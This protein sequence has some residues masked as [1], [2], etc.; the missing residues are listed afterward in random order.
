M[1]GGLNVYAFFDKLGEKEKEVA[2]FIHVGV[3][4]L[5][6]DPKTDLIDKNGTNYVYWSDGSIRNLTESS[7]NSSTSMVIK[8]DYKYETTVKDSVK[9]FAKNSLYVPVGVG[10]KFQMGFRASLRVGVAY[11]LVM[12]DYV[13]GYKK[14]GNDSWVSASV[15]LN[16][17][18]GKKPSDPYSNVDFKSVDNS[19]TDGDGVKDLDDRCFGTPKGVKVD[20]KG[21]PEDKDDDGVFDYMDKELTTKKGAKVDGTGVTINEDAMAKRQLMWD[22]LSTERSEGFNNAP[23]LEYLKKVE[24]Q[25]KLNKPKSGT[26]SKIPADFLPADFNNDGYIS[27]T[28]IT[29]AIDGFFDGES[30][31]TVEKINKLIDYFFEQ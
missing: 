5:M 19:D 21:C 29:K 14:G 1:G 28:E 30:S 24:E 7:S 15:G 17:H 8:R 20:G 22:S 4:Y 27:A 10:A 18:F 13:D 2:P 9:S 16:I 25:A 6:F 11:N 31:F 26:A 12:S 3:G 23:S